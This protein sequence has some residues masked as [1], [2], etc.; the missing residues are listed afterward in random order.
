M[1]GDF[2]ARSFEICVILLINGLRLFADFV[3]DSLQFMVYVDLILG[4]I[5]GFYDYVVFVLR[6]LGFRG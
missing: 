5:F 2:C 3:F 6:L 4:V 1:F